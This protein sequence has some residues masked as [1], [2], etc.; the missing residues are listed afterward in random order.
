[1]SRLERTLYQNF[2]DENRYQILKVCYCLGNIL[3]MTKV[4]TI[5]LFYPGIPLFCLAL[6]SLILTVLTMTI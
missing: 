5:T 3:F 2:I 4:E 1:M 6:L